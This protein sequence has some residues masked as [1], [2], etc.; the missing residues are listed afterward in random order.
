MALF[1]A[2]AAEKKLNDGDSRA[3]GKTIAAY[4][5]IVDQFIELNGDLPASAISREHIRDYRAQLAQLPAS[6]EGIRALSAK[7]Q[8]EKAELERLPTLSAPTIRNK[9]RAL[10]AVLSHGVRMGLLTENAVI[11]SGS[12]KA[13]AKAASK[14]S[15][16]NRRRKD[17]TSEELALIFAS[18]IFSPGGWSSPRADFGKA[19]YW[20]PLLMYYTGAR[21]EEIAQLAVK[22]VRASGGREVISYLSILETEDEDEGRGVKTESSRRQIPLHL[23]LIDRGFLSYVAALPAGLAPRGLV[24]HAAADGQGDCRTARIA[25]LTLANQKC[26]PSHRATCCGWPCPAPRPRC[27]GGVAGIRER[28][29]RGLLVFSA[30]SDGTQS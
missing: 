24:C 14:G 30:I 17:Y 8:I 3:V 27:S 5:A 7:K 1:D 16:A 22:D 28:V 9:L 21:R 13:A 18:P 29:A 25:R 11:A 19:W 4:R 6:G 12:A 23:D 20:V 10:S 2:Y 26:R 15:A